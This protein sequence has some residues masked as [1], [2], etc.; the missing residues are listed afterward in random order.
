MSFEHSESE[1]RVPRSRINFQDRFSSS[2]MDV[3]ARKMTTNNPPAPTPNTRVE[4]ME[5]NRSLSQG[6]SRRLLSASHFSL[7]SLLLLICLT[8]S[9]LILPLVLPPLPPPPFM[10]LL[11]PIGILALL[12]FL[13]FMPSNARDITYTCGCCYRCNKS[14]SVMKSSSCGLPSV[15][16]TPSSAMSMV[17]A[18]YK[19]WPE[20][21]SLPFFLQKQAVLLMFT[22]V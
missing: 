18:Q 3:R 12:M 11:L 13:A 2:I 17:E 4:K 7:V 19:V 15:V 1:T 20:L 6:S 9:L 21:K 5:Y 8:A 16:Y 10:L 14:T 22:C